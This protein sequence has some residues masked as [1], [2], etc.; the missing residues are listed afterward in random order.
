MSDQ[1]QP[2]WA[3]LSTTSSSAF[4]FQASSRFSLA[5]SSFPG[6]LGAISSGYQIPFKPMPALFLT[7]QADPSHQSSVSS[8]TATSLWVWASCCSKSS[9]SHHV[10]P[11]HHVV[12][13]ILKVLFHSLSHPAHPKLPVL[14]LGDPSL[15]FLLLLLVLRQKW[16]NK[17]HHENREKNNTAETLLVLFGFSAWLLFRGFQKRKSFWMTK[18]A[19]EQQ[20]HFISQVIQ[21]FCV[22][23]LTQ[24]WTLAQTLLTLLGNSSELQQHSDIHTFLSHVFQMKHS[25]PLNMEVIKWQTKGGEPT[26][27]APRTATFS[28]VHQLTAPPLRSIST[29]YS[30]CYS[31]RTSSQLFCWGRKHNNADRGTSDM[32]KIIDGQLLRKPLA[33]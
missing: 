23:R 30:A 11:P 26:G 1:F 21:E 7:P 12:F 29:Q 32:E 4:F 33:V 17:R 10:C 27:A 24:S 16:G 14:M 3:V 9:P 8:L 15:C 2:C 19:R 28:S 25:C 18:V 5:T 6:Q 13:P 20:E 22:R 31:C